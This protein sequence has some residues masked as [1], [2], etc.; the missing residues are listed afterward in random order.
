MNDEIWKD[1]PGYEG[2]Y[3]ASSLGRIKSLSRI[4]NGK[5]QFGTFEWKCDESLLRPGTRSKLGYQMVV[6]N[7]PRKTFAVHHLVMLAFVGARN[8]LY[9]LHENG[10]P[11]DNR[12][13]NL[14]YDTQSENVIDVY[15]QGK[16][17]RKLTISDVYDI[18]FALLCG[19]TCV[20]IA[21]AY[22]VGHQAISKIKNGERY[23]WLK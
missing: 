12:L 18:R 22:G 15:R 16:A 19:F 10:D 17:W 11:K 13:I 1:I 6:L 8:D 9:V 20:N 3:Q 23:K 7:D 2:K 21:K 5:N 4:I 14:R